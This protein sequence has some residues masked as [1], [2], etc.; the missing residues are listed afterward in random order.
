MRFERRQSPCM[1]CLRVSN[2]QECENKSCKL[3]QDWFVA[4]WALLHSYSRRVMDAPSPRLGVTI[5]GV[6]YAHPVQVQDYRKDDPCNGC[7]CTADLCKTP[8]RAR[9]NWAK[10]VNG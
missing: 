5:G 10:A 7:A 4:R 9:Q 2:P 3:W 1:T 8:C 6:C